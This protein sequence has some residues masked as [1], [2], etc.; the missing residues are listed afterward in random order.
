MNEIAHR[1]IT[2]LRESDCFLVFDRLK[3]DFDFPIHFHTEYELNFISN[4]KGAKRIV[5]D[6]ICEIDNLELV[7]IGPNVPHC[8][9]NCNN[10]KQKEMNE[11]TIQ[12]PK[13]L[14]EEGILK[15]NILKPIKDLLSH[16]SRGIAF[17]QTTILQVQ[18]RIKNLSLKRGFDSFIEVYTLL[19][20]LAI[21]R[22][23]QLLTNIS[24]QNNDDFEN[25]ERIEKL[26]NY[27]KANFREKIM[28]D[29]ASKL[30]N[31][32][33]VTFTRFIRQRTGKSFVNFMNEI[34]LGHAT[35][36]LIDTNDSISEI[37][38]ECG[39]NNTSNFNRIFKKK[40]NATPS[41]FR[42]N[43]KGVRTVY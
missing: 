24:F 28:L 11:I 8:W 27:I 12:I 33:T 23:M 34:R 42:S 41:E 19:Y 32:S 9:K 21:S 43:F 35:R 20:D 36:L 26:Y 4:A 13:D 29:D 1:E 6:H 7:L 31:M 30:L 39:F 15:K 5:G 17:S 25:S 16:S 18:D 38:F 40:Q 14:F 22:E 3:Y 37:C 2:P 10:D